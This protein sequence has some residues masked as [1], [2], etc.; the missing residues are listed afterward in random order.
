MSDM[1]K[2]SPAEIIEEAADGFA[3][4][5]PDARAARCLRLALALSDGPER[6]VEAAHA[7]GGAYE[8]LL[9]REQRQMLLAAA[10]RAAHI[11]DAITIME[12]AIDD[13]RAMRAAGPEFDP[14]SPVAAE[15]A[16]SWKWATQAPRRGRIATLMAC[17][18]ASS[19]FDKRR[20]SERLGGRG[21]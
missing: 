21:G 20:I 18:M 12:A 9:T 19:D 15:A 6:A 1:E 3:D 2:P 7:L 8:A 16:E 14:Q 5:P 13:L 17:F 11:D 10:I 4:S